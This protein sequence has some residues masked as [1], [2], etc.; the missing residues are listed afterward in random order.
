M[1][2]K[3]VA[4]FASGVT[5]WEAIVHATLALSGKLPFTWLGFT[6]TPTINTVQIILPAIISVSLAYYAW[7]R[8]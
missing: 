7:G 6:I 8:K 5:A 2:W 3:E 1:N 4:K